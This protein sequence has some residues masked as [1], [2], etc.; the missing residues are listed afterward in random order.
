MKCECHKVR[1]DDIKQTKKNLKCALITRP[2]SVRLN[3]TEIRTCTKEKVAILGNF[4]INDGEGKLS[5]FT[6]YRKDHQQ[7]GQL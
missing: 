2:L 1:T 7:I 6:H 4:F 5:R 3:E